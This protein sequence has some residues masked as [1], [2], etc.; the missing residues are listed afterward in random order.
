M[1]WLLL[2]PVSQPEPPLALQPVLPLELQLERPSVPWNLSSLPPQ[3]ELQLPLP[4]LLPQAPLAVG[5][6][7]RRP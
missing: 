4:L 5:W 7:R 2:V 1:A 6:Y 3:P